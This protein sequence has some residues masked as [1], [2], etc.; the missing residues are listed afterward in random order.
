MIRASSAVWTSSL[1]YIHGDPFHGIL[2]LKHLEAVRCSDPRLESLMPSKPLRLNPL[3]KT[4]KYRTPL[5][6]SCNPA[7]HPQEKSVG[8]ATHVVVSEELGDSCLTRCF[9]NLALA[10]WFLNSS[11]KTPKPHKL[12]S[13]KKPLKPPSPLSPLSP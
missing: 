10:L 4:I 9:R 11:P 3:R 5:E 1:R 2:V 13:P 12:L 6:W 8:P 7:Q